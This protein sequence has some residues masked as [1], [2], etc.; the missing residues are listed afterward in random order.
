MLIYSVNRYVYVCVCV[1][2]VREIDRQTD[3]LLF[4]TSYLQIHIVHFSVSPIN[5]YTLRISYLKL[6]HLLNQKA[7]NLRTDRSRLL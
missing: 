4:V 3:I 1:C 2:E 6:Q 5:N 7:E